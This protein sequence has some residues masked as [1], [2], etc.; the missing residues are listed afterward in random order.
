MAFATVNV[1]F[2]DRIIAAKD[3]RAQQM[4]LAYENRLSISSFPMTN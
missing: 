1:I 2:K 4:Q 3:R